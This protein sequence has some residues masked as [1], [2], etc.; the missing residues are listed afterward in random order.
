MIGAADRSGTVL[1]RN[2]PGHADLGCADLGHADLKDEQ[3]TDNSDVEPV[4]SRGRLA[5]KMWTR[6]AAAVAAGLLFCFALVTYFHP[7][8]LATHESWWLLIVAMGVAVLG[9]SAHTSWQT[10]GFVAAT[11]VI[12]FGAQLALKQPLWFQFIRIQPTSDFSYVMLCALILQGVTAALLLLRMG[13]WASLDRV[14]SELGQ[15]RPLVAIL[16]LFVF[17]LGALDFIGRQLYGTLTKQFVVAVSLVILNLTSFL[18]LVTAMPGDRLRTLSGTVSAYLSL[19]GTG[20]QIRKFDAWLPLWL[21][22]GVLILCVFMRLVVFEGI[23]RIDEVLYLFQAQYFAQG[24]LTLP[25]PAS[26][27]AFEVFMMNSYDDKWFATWPPGWPMILA[28]GVF[29]HAPWIVNPLL[30][31]CSVLLLHAFMKSVAD[32]GMANLATILLAVSPWYLSTSSTLMSHTATYAFILGAWVLLLRARTRPSLASPLLAGGLMGMVFLTRPLEG[33][34]IGVL[35]GLWVLSLARDRNHWKTVVLYGVGCLAIGG[36]VFPYNAHLTGD[37]FHTP[38]NTYLNVAWGEGTN[39]FGFGEGI[40]AP[41]WG[42]VDPFAGHSP[43]EALVQIQHMAYVL[44]FELLGWGFGSIAFVVV[45]ALWGKWSK[46]SAG[47]AAI[48]VVT[49][50]AHAFYWYAAGYYAGPRYWFLTLVPMVVLSA[51]GILVCAEKAEYLF[52]DRLAA[53]RI[54]AGVALLCLCSLAVFVNWLGFNKYHPEFRGYH[55]DYQ[56]LAKREDL[57]NSLVFVAADSAE[58]Y[59]NAFWLNDFRPQSDQPLFAKDLDLETNLQVASAYP[60]RKIFFVEGRSEERG[61]AEIVRGP[62]TL[63]DLE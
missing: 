61:T 30:A 31:A 17:S 14:F 50:V 47:M 56:M 1:A 45:F 15:V 49:I 7:G 27:E 5:A 3:M 4:E 12:G 39:R 26:I 41:G 19:P 2:G 8:G 20:N 58:E 59:E 21:A 22:G 32:R 57:K 24:R 60:E 40:G 34:L 55:S 13:L 18:A 6:P 10:A 62:L 9:F 63:A 43:L 35:T 11:F 25:L 46:L 51:F 52:P 53:Q 44:N 23:P 16:V 36:L 33:V 42:R 38:L 48:V 29:F 28:V 37:A 54:G